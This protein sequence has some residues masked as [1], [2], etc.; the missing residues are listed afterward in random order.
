MILDGHIESPR[1]IISSS[2]IYVCDVKYDPWDF[3][4]A[5]LKYLSGIF[6]VHSLT[7]QFQKIG[8]GIFGCLTIERG[9]G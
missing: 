6:T 9:A 1:T 3:W 4:G 2:Y 7:Q 5:P 8:E